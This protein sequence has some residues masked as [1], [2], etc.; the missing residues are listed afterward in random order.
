MAVVIVA[1]ALANKP[2]NGGEAWVRLSWVRGLQRLGCD[3]YFVEQVASG[4]GPDREYFRAVTDRFALA[5]RA[6]LVCGE[7]YEG[8]SWDRLL[9]AAGSAELL[10][11]IS[12]HLTL[13]PLLDRI[14]RK[15]YVDLDPGFTQ[16]W[17]ADPATPF[18]VGGH[19]FY[20]TVGQNIGSPD[21]PMPTGGIPWRPVRQPVVLADWPV[22]GD[23]RPDRF[24]TVASWRGAFGPVTFAGRTYGLKVHEFR[25]VIGLP[26]RSPH[27]F[28]IAL[29]IHPADAKDRS[30][31]V[32]NGW[33]LVAPADVAADPDAFRRYVQTSGA[34][35]SVAQ[36][37]Y[38]ETNSGWFSDRTVRYL[39]S[40]K[41]ALVQDTGFGRHLPVGAGLVAFRTAD[42]AVAGADAIVRGYERHCRAARAIAE[43]YFDSDKV[44]GRFLEEVGVAP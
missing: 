3:V 11:N 17:H 32:E 44:L 27:T 6:A 1:G 9:A 15:A 20:F 10:V 23:G 33:R 2:G 30:A 38:V 26:R 41:P 25:K 13:A 37:V 42:E 18:A 31:L 21:C 34:E 39:A 7:A 28:E 43:T 5:G 14:R 35:F 12:G 22:C 8:L 19:D 24:T 36:G 29:D 16:F 4:A 40:G